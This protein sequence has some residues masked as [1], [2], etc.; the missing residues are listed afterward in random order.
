MRSIVGILLVVGISLISGCVSSQTA[1]QS[2]A[3]DMERE[4]RLAEVASVQV[5]LP[6][7]TPYD[8]D[9]EARQAYL[10]YYRDGYRNGLAGFMSTCC[11]MEC[12]NR[13]AR[14]AGW[15][16]GQSAGWSVWSKKNL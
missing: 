10:D 4:R 2:A 15:Y 11:L 6:Q 13:S 1:S 5:S 3:F 14:V 9:V 7:T 12:P 16:A 8:A